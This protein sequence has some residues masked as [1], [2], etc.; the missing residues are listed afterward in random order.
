MTQTRHSDVKFV[1]ELTSHI[2]ARRKKLA[3]VQ[4]KTSNTIDK[5]A[6]MCDDR[7]QLESGVESRGSCQTKKALLWMTTVRARKLRDRTQQAILSNLVKRRKLVLKLFFIVMSLLPCD[8]PLTS[9]K[10]SSQSA[11]RSM[12]NFGGP[13]TFEMY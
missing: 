12:Q 2:C 3:R 13:S 9:P 11:S 5:M 7:V 6:N 4:I 1:S 10:I 8:F